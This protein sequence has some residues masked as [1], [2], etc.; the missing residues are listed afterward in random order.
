MIWALRTTDER[1]PPT[2]SR[3][4]YRRARCSA[5]STTD[6]R[7][8]GGDDLDGGDDTG[9][10]DR[11]ARGFRSAVLHF[12]RR[13]EIPLADG[14]VITA[15]HLG[16]LLELRIGFV[17]RLRFRSSLDGAPNPVRWEGLDVRGDVVSGRLV[18][19]AGVA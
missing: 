4:L 5:R 17:T 16:R 10:T 12:G 14:G 11:V 18:L 2:V 9:T 19:D 6:E 7:S 8:G 3:A 1:R 13:F 15:R